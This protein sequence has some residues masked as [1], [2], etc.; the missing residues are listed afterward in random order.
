MV[1]FIFLAPWIFLL[2][3]PISLGTAYI[4]WLHH[5][6]TSLI[7]ILHKENPKDATKKLLDF[8]NEFGKFVGYKINTQKSVRLLYT[9]NKRSERKRISFIIISKRTK[10]LGKSLPKEG[11]TCTAKTIRHWWEK[12]MMIPT[13]EKIYH[14]LGLEESTLSK[15]YTAQGNL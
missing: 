6:G 5:I 1:S 10:Y 14:V 7:L 2:T 15:Y 8:I 11:K 3:R 13:E 9:N 4:A 12:S